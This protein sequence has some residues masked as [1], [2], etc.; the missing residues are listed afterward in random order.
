MSDAPRPDV[1]IVVPLLNEEASVAELIARTRSAVE[2][3]GRSFELVLV[4]DGSQDRTAALLREA[5]HADPRLRVFELTRNFGQN[6]ALACGIF[7]ARGDI[8]VTLDGD[9]QNP[10]EEIPKLLDALDQGADVA[11]GLRAQR[12][13]S[14]PRWLGSRAIHL[15]ARHLTGA[16]IRD[17]GGQFKAYRRHVVDALGRVWAPGKPI[18]PLALWLGFPVAEVEVR[19]D[20]RR[21]GTSRYSLR[22]L[23]R[24]NLDLIT[25]FSTLPLAAIGMAG[26]GALAL[27]TVGT[28]FCLFLDDVGWFPGA[29]SLTLLGVG[30]LLTASGVVGQYVGRIYGRVAGNSPAYVVR[31]EPRPRERHS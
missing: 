16:D 26:A 14:F 7:E 25:S 1:S 30:A 10:P 3:T 4:D 6:A 20:S 23:L 31:S 2:A 11:T 5:E 9:L 15:V 18:F 19:H 12:Y 27:G 8:V 28:V 17:F 21:A 13:E 29:L 24:I 22:S